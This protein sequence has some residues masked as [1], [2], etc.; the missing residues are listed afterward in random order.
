MN[1]IDL[2]EKFLPILDEIY[3]ANSKTAILDSKIRVLDHSAAN[4]VQIFKTSLTGLATTTKRPVSRSARSP[5]PG[6]TCS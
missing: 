3:A 1:A 5:A 4:K 6:K 2:A